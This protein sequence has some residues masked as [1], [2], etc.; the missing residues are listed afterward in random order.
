MTGAAERGGQ[1]DDVLFHSLPFRSFLSECSWG[2]RRKCFAGTGSVFRRKIMLGHSRNLH[3][4]VEELL[5][6]YLGAVGALGAGPAAAA[7]ATTVVG[8]GVLGRV[9]SRVGCQ[10]KVVKNVRCAIWAGRGRGRERE[11]CISLSLPLL[12]RFPLFSHIQKIPVLA[13]I[14]DAKAK[15]KRKPLQCKQEELLAT[16]TRS[17]IHSTLDS[18]Q[19][20]L[21]KSNM[22]KV[23]RVLVS[24][25]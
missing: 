15:K 4:I 5:L 3:Q 8:H 9:R 13:E 10:D 1:K 23:S 18:T 17:G 20:A 22:L 21:R 16:T 12:S 7:A 11:E 24:M 2:Q 6:E 14:K 19:W 25:Q